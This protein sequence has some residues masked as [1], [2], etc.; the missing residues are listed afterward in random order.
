M[1]VGACPENTHGVETAGAC[2][3]VNTHPGVGLGHD[4][5]LKVGLGEVRLRRD[6]AA[7]I[8]TRRG[9]LTVAT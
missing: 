8:E 3:I 5:L 1:Q 4:D 2:Y 6:N 7:Q 9:F